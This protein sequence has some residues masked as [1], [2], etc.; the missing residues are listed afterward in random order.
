MRS[1]LEEA[2][3]I[4]DDITADVSGEF[5]VDLLR[6]RKLLRDLRAEAFLDPDDVAILTPHGD[7]ELMYLGAEPMQ[8]EP[9]QPAA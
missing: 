2:L 3:A 1:K 4:I 8:T 6:V 9:P 5:P 7:G